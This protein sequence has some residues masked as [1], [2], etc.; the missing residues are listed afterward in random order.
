MNTGMTIDGHDAYTTWGVRL[1]AGSLGSVVCWP[2]LKEA[3]V[4]VNRWQEETGLDADLSAPRLDTR[5]VTLNLAV[6]SG[7]NG[8]RRFVTAVSGRGERTVVFNALGRSFRLRPLQWGRYDYGAELGFVTVTMADDHPLDNYTYIMPIVAE[9]GDF[10]YQLPFVLGG[11]LADGEYAMDGRPLN[12]YGV[13]LLDGTLDGIWS[14]GEARQP[15]V[16]NLPHVDG[17][18]A[19]SVLDTR[20]N[21]PTMVLTALLRADNAADMWARWYALLYDLVR[22][23]YRTLGG[24]AGEEERRFY[25]RGCSVLEFAI[26]DLS[27]AWIKFNITV[28]P[29]DWL[30]VAAGDGFPYTLPILL[31]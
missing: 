23:G 24:I 17:V 27:G 5:K 8:W 7:Y 19:Y 26:D 4:P 15:L 25:Y 9:N 2:P 3:S 22:P 18:S 1:L 30:P 12:R 14:A 11:T 20:Y 31:G 13:H 16:R 29:L 6:D 28:Q 21:A 10:P